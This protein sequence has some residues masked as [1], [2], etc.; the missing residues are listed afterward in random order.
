MLDVKSDS[1]GVLIPRLTVSQRDQIVSPAVGLLIFNTTNQSFDYYTGSV[2]QSLGKAVANGNNAGDMLVWNGNQWQPAGFKYYHADRDG[3]GLGDPFNIVYSEVPPTGYVLND[4]D[5]D[6]NNSF[7]GG[8][9]SRTYY[10][11]RDGDGHGDPTGIPATGCI[12]PPGYA[13]WNQD[14]CDDTNPLIFPGASEICDGI[15][16]D[17]DGLIDE[18]ITVF[19]DQDQDFFGDPSVS[20]LTCV[21]IPAG[22]VTNSMDCNDS[23][24]TIN[25]MNPFEA[26]D[27]VD[28]NCDGQ[29]DESPTFVFY[30]SDGDG[31]G[32]ISN[33]MEWP[34]N[35]PLPAGYSFSMGD[36]NDYDPQFH[37]GAAEICDGMDNNCNGLI[38][39]NV[40]TLTT[41]YADAD[42]DLYGNPSVTTTATGCIPPAGFVGNSM[43]CDD[44]N[45]A[46]N[47]GIQESCNGIDDNCNGLID[48]GV[49]VDGQLFFFD[50]DGDGYGEPTQSLKLCYA[51]WG[52]VANSDDCDDSDPTIYLGATEICDGK[53]NNCNYQVD[54]NVTLLHWYYDADQ[55]GF[56]DNANFV[57]ACVPYWG[58]VSAGNDCDDNNPGIYPGAVEIC[59]GLDNDCNG[60]IDDNVPSPTLWYIDADGDG[61]GNPAVSVANCTS[62]AGYVGNNADCNDSNAGIHPGV[63]E[64][65]DGVDNNCNGEVDEFSYQAVYWYLDSDGDG[66]GTFSSVYQNCTP[67][68]GYV[69][70]YGDC[71]D[72]NA[73]IHP[74]APEICGNGLDDDCDGQV[75]EP[76]CQ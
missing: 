8:G 28:N 72:A 45:P 17:C 62:P 61:Y 48:E 49:T 69:A 5:G 23:D 70:L 64:I 25:P 12:A 34:C 55:D 41:F 43:D 37:P 2:W 16:N 15:D 54:E 31:Y 66:Y 63:N 33:P 1:K 32:N 67:I 29:I 46:L 68:P 11:D 75:D 53:D 42:N 47:P 73:S 74:N 71:N 38:D 39:E 30:D 6:D 21:P 9:T 13:M 56:G 3:D 20:L 4:C 7:S 76:G 65:C 24:P 59:D 58:Y 44:S 52:Y 18:K 35:Q 57:E 14:D 36:C 19:A 51:Q 40:T 60:L 10:P 22:Y 27:G 50:N 26:C